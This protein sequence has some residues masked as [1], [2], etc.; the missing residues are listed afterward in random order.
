MKTLVITAKCMYIDKKGILLIQV[1]DKEVLSSITEGELINIC[2]SNNG[3]NI[4]GVVNET[5]QTCIKLRNWRF[6]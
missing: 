1:K 6:C 3:A 5:T 4:I 2:L